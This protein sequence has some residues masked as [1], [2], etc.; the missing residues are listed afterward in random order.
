MGEQ[1][2]VFN[3]FEEQ[4]SFEIMSGEKMKVNARQK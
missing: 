4:V 1:A 3:V 2:V